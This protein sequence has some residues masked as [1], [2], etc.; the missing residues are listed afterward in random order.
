MCGLIL[1]ALRLL[2]FFDLLFVT[3]QGMLEVADPFAQTFRDFGNFLAA[4]QQHGNTEDYE[5]LRK[6]K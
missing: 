2:L 6:A 4:E 5:K 1:E 3:L